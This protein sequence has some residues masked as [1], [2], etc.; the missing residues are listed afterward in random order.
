MEREKGKN[1]LCLL[2]SHSASDE[3]GGQTPHE[4]KGTEGGRKGAAT[5]RRR[6][7]CTLF[8]YLRFPRRVPKRGKYGKRLAS[9]EACDHRLT[10]AAPGPFERKGREKKKEP[11]K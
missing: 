10:P 8:A 1:P 2:K 4:E 6:K 7:N 3:R 9:D 5:G 11:S